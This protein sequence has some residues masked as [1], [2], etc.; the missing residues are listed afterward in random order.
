MNP[1]SLLHPA[2]HF[3]RFMT[4]LHTTQ[5]SPPTDFKAMIQRER[6]LADRNGRILSLLIFNTE[7]APPQDVDALVNILEKRLRETDDIGWLAQHELGA[8]L[9]QT[10]YRGAQNLAVVLNARLADRQVPFPWRIL[11]YPE[12]R[13]EPHPQGA[14][15]VPVSSLLAT[16]IP[17][18]KRLT[19]ITLSTSALILLSPLLAVIALGILIL[20]P[21]PILFRQE[22]IGYLGRRFQCLKFRSMTAHAPTTVHREY[23]QHLIHSDV[24]MKKLDGVNDTRIIPLGHLLRASALDELPQ[25]MNVLKGDMSLV[26]PRPCLPYEFET[27]LHWHKRRFDTLPGLTGLWQVSGKNKTSFSEMMRLDIAYERRRSFLFD[28]L[29][30]ARTPLVVIDQFLEVLTPTTKEHAYESAR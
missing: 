9:R 7:N 3:P 6:A 27:F 26:G 13:P 2:S 4:N 22:R 29:I 16:P 18:W 10:D 1:A 30:M 11:C 17:R 5:I 12:I 28:L 24:P 25:L 23:L 20:A 8:L 21:G 14:C 19:D 15:D